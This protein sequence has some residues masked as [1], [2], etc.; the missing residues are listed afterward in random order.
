MDGLEGE[1]GRH[2]LFSPTIS[3]NL[4]AQNFDDLAQHFEHLAQNID[5]FCKKVSQD[6]IRSSYILRSNF[7]KFRNV[8]ELCFRATAS[9]G[10]G[11][12]AVFRILFWPIRIPWPYSL[13]RLYGR[14][15]I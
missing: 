1:G 3:H 6:N 11:F 5:E 8:L 4:L 12:Q 15:F 13:E 14:N 2:L 10:Y 9:K 7:V